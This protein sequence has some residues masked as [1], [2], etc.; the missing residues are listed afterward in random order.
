MLFSNGGNKENSFIHSFIYSF[1]SINLNIFNNILIFLEF[2]Y[3]VCFISVSLVRNDSVFDILN[4]Y[5]LLCFIL[6]SN[7]LHYNKLIITYY[8]ISIHVILPPQAL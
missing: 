5:R 1:L 2:V 6:W 7:M 4:V 8:V 3:I